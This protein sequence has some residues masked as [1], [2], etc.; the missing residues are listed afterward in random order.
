MDDWDHE[1]NKN[2]DP[3]SLACQS[4][5]KVAWR[6][7]QCGHR[8]S[9]GIHSRVRQ[10]SG[11]PAC[12]RAKRKYSNRGLLKD[13]HP[14]ISAEIHP[15]RN[16]DV[17]VSTLTC[18]SGQELWWL[19]MREDGRPEGCQCEHA[20]KASVRV[21]CKQNR[22]T[23]CPF[24]SGRAVCMCNSVAGLHP[25]L[26]DRYWCFEMH[27][28]LDTGATGACS[29]QKVWWEHLCVDRRMHRQQLRVNDVVRQFE[30]YSRI[31]CRI[32]ANKEVSAHFAKHHGRVVDRD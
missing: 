28:G 22:P 1:A 20:W 9:A 32:C 7:Q 10:G 14:D 12:A 3:E 24:H 23:G 29:N 8:W 6:C 19:C 25:D 16:A 26:V 21:R 2:L 4:R 11:C 13:E 17:N 30:R 5:M 27:E 18:G 15:S 31:S